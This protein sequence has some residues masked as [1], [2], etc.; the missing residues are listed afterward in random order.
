MKIVA[1]AFC[2][3][4]IYAQVRI[5]DWK[6]FTSPLNVRQVIGTDEQIIAATEGGLFIFD[7]QN[8]YTLTTIEGLVGVDLGAVGRDSM[9][10]IW[11]GGALPFGFIQVYDIQQN[12]SIDVFEFGLT[13]IFDF[14]ILDSLAFSW[15]QDG[16]DMGIMKFVYEQGWQYRDSYKNFPSAMGVITGFTATNTII[17]L[18]AESGVWAGYLNSNL[19]DPNNWLQPFPNLMIP[20][21]AVQKSGSSILVSTKESLV[22]IDPI[23]MMTIPFE[24][25][26][27]TFSFENMVNYHLGW[28][29]AKGKNLFG[30]GSTGNIVEVSF[31]YPITALY[32]N[33]TDGLVVGSEN[34]FQLLPEASVDISSNS[35]IGFIPN[36]PITSG[37]TAIAVLDDG[38]L[39][40]GSSHGLSILDKNGW[41]N[42]LEIKSSN[43][44]VIHTAYD[45][46]DFIAD[47]VPY[48]FG[49]YIAD[50]EQGPDGLVYCSIRGSRIYLANPPRFSGGII[51]VDVDDPTNITTIDTTHLSYHTTSSNSI[52]Y[53]VVLD[54][55]FDSDGNMW[56]ADP[57]SINGNNPVHV[58][59]TSGV[60]KH[61]GS[62][63]TAIKIS[64]SPNAITFDSWKRVWVSAFQAEEANLG[65]Y[66]N[67]GLFMLDF[68][69]VPY[70]PDSFTWKKVIADGTIRSL[71]MG[72][73]DR[74]YYL[75]PSG[76]N[77]Y[78]LKNDTNPVVREN[79]YAYFPN[80]SFGNGAELKVD[81]HGN[82]WTHSPTQ[83]VH[84]LLENT[85]YWPDIN[86]FRTSNSP[87]LSNQINDIDFDAENSLAYIATSKGVNVVRIPFGLEKKDFTGVKV[88][89]SP[90]YLPA[91]KPM[92]VD[93]VP[94]ES[95]M[96]IMT[97]DG[98]VIRKIINQGIS[99][100]G[101][102]ISWDGRDREGDYV[103]SGVYLLAIYGFDGKNSVE[104]ITV[105]RR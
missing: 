69:G 95:S 70:N 52:P 77:Y 43:S 60:W 103:S 75:T 88:Y 82:I 3:S 87:L 98:S 94:F 99:I 101:D 102:Q 38:R 7:D 47:T 90:F 39:V 62:A 21:T 26:L 4:L 64:Q 91:E 35:F 93:G 66:P 37:F 13:A 67:G 18:G 40:G 86:G 2:I 51:I 32:A 71:A 81:P 92:K 57:Y 55:E 96:I 12:R 45:Y 58:R 65:I 54:V 42:I 34:G 36:A 1:L 105:I 22:T 11:V 104:K 97:L 48:D 85:T 73:Q 5:G 44:E 10:K 100:D 72:K 56:V 24:H 78:D 83:G 28:W 89:P 16:Q 31:D 79:P 8:Y 17:F 74:L 68:D 41:R 25:P 33:E 29:F 61:F 76:L 20:V 9:D 19:K 49:G 15:F 46:S 63:E 59:S 6:A 80:I 23:E 14:E 84:V 27:T 30:P 53:L 50:L